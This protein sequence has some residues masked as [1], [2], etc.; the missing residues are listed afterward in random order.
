MRHL[1]LDFGT[2]NTVL[3]TWDDVSDTPS[4]VYLPDLSIAAADQP[5][6][7]PS[8]VYVHDDGRLTSGFGV[9]ALHLNERNNQQ[10]FRNFK[11]SLIEITAPPPR[12][13]AGRLW[14]DREI[15]EHFIRQIFAGLPES[16]GDID[17][18]VI[19]VPVA[20]FQGYVTW[21]NG[22]LD[23]EVRVV[24]ESTAAALGYAITEP[25]ALVLVF[26]FGGGTLDL[27]LVRLPDSRAQTGA[28]LT[29]LLSG[30]A[31]A[32]RATVVAKAGRTLGGS[33]VDQ[34]L[35]QWV[36]D[37]LEL[38][39]AGDG[40]SALLT[41]CEQAKI[42]LSSAESAVVMLGSQSITITRHD[43]VRLLEENGFFVG[44]RRAIDRVLVTARQQGIFK[45]DL[46]YVLMVGGMSLMP[47]VQDTLHDCFATAVVR[48][49]KPFTA[50]AEGALQVARGFGVEDYLA[51]GFGLRH[52]DP[53]TGA[54]HFE[55]IIP[56]GTPYPLAKPVE[57]ILGA[58]HDH[59]A[60]IELVIG[61]IDSD[62]VAMLE[63]HYHDGQAVFVAQSDSAPADVRLLNATQPTLLDLQPA[64]T[65]GPE[66]I[67]A[68]FTVDDKR[69]LR[70]IVTDL[71]ARKTLLRNR[72]V[73]TL[74]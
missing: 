31:N 73:T 61:E 51:H 26:D 25:G 70:V 5:P 47:A 7:V 53:V 38:T 35:A 52:L 4:L 68:A 20:A 34:W 1:A 67:K 60:Q 17:Q 33:D 55:E 29:R 43:L 54:H 72:V 48:A 39:E 3:A 74:H 66:R 36:L 14:Q 9:R 50:V 42:A 57:V 46:H 23:Q 22:I 16:L 11:R 30:N 69:Q 10:L 18:L 13:I 49:H 6:L 59:Q 28:A 45:E 63:V 21:L 56:M 62:A 37:Q 12:F 2:T 44:L 58:A 41:Q 65:P 64:G 15:G 24:D 19:T 8:L 32:Y 27:S 40:Y 71:Q